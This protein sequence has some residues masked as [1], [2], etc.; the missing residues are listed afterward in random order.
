MTLDDTGHSVS[1]S[2]AFGPDSFARVNDIHAFKDDG[3]FGM[4][5]FLPLTLYVC[6]MWVRL[7]LILNT[8]IFYTAVMSG[9]LRYRYF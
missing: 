3:N 8:E 4:Y 2:M 1:H 7:Y 6:W 9:H 5:V